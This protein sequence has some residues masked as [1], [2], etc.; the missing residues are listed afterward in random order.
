MN[1]TDAL[2]I[3]AASHTDDFECDRELWTTVMSIITTHAK[4]TL[5]VISVEHIEVEPPAALL[6]L[7][8][9]DVIVLLHVPEPMTFMLTISREWVGHRGEITAVPSVTGLLYKC[10][11]FGGPEFFASRDMLRKVEP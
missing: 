2:A 10:K 9:R 5:A 1:I 7:A 6:D 3:Y 4:T 8:V 11:M